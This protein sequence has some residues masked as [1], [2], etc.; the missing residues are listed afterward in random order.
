MTVKI[1]QG[2]CLDVLDTLEENSVDCC[3]TSPPYFNL[4]DYQTATWIGGDPNCSHKRDSKYSESCS[5]GQKLL[6]GAIGDG[7]YLSVCKRCGAVRK[8]EQLGLEETPEEYVNSMADVFDKVHRVLKPDG[9]LWLNLGDTWIGGGRGADYCKDGTIQQN[10]IDAG[11]SYQKPTKET[12]IYKGKDLAGI[13]FRVA[14]E[15]HKR[16]WYFRQDIIWHKPNCMPESVRDRCTKSHEYVFLMSKSKHY[17]YDQ[18][19]I[20][21]PHTWEES[22]PK[23]NIEERKAQKYLDKD[24]YGGGGSGLKGHSGTNK[25]D[26]T[27]LNHPLGRNKRSVWSI[28]S[29]PYKESHFAIFPPK[30]IEPMIKAGCKEGGV[31]LDCFAGSGTTGLVADQLGRDAILI[32]L[33]SD[34]ID[35]IEKRI[36]SDAPLFTDYDIEFSKK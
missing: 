6:E 2:N 17:Y 24:N 3:I 33:N 26:G 35:L 21:E 7:I 15:L 8:D 31:V 22:K 28:H 13:P 9:T 25:A 34:Y 4:R 32:E 36:T 29:K 5:T 11:V 14:F 18:D 23:E 1:I 12:G 27:P 20:R 19:A 30:L 16:G 10:H